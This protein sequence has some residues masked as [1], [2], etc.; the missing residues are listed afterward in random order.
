VFTSTGNFVTS[1]GA[2]GSGEGQLDGPSG[3]AVA[4]DGT[5][6]VVDSQNSRIQAFAPSAC[7]AGATHR[8]KPSGRDKGRDGHDRQGKQRRGK[9][10][11]GK[12]RGRKNGAKQRRRN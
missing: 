8:Q 3:V 2:P 10:D 4:G 7:I 6:Y 5:V 9:G 11:H 12:H 1:F